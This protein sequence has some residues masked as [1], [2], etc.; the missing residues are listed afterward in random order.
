MKRGVSLCIVFICSLVTYAKTGEIFVNLMPGE[1]SDKGVIGI[2]KNE[3]SDRSVVVFRKDLEPGKYSFEVKNGKYLVVCMRYSHDSIQTHPIVVRNDSVTE[4]VCKSIPNSELI[5]LSGTVIDKETG[6]PIAGAKVGLYLFVLPSELVSHYSHVIK[7]KR[8]KHDLGDVVRFLRRYNLDKYLYSLTDSKG[9]FKTFV[10]TKAVVASKTINFTVFAEGY[11]PFYYKKRIK[12]VRQLKTPVDVGTIELIASSSFRISLVPPLKKKVAMFLKPVNTEIASYRRNYFEGFPY[13]MLGTSSKSPIFIKDK[14]VWSFLYPWVY[15]VESIIESDR[16]I[17]PSASLAVYGMKERENKE[18]VLDINECEYEIEVVS[19][20]NRDENIAQRDTKDDF[21]ISIDWRNRYLVVDS[22]SLKDL[23]NPIKV[24]DIT[25]GKSFIATSIKYGEEEEF[26]IEEIGV[27][28]TRKVSIT[29][30]YS[31]VEMNDCTKDNKVSL[32]LENDELSFVIRDSAGKPVKSAD[33]FAYLYKEGYEPSFSCKTR[34]NSEGKA[35]CKYLKNGEYLVFIH[36]PQKGYFGPETFA[37]DS[38]SYQITLK[39]GKNVQVELLSPE[40][41]SVGKGMGIVAVLAGTPV[42]LSAVLNLEGEKEKPYRIISFKKSEREEKYVAK[43]Y[44]LPYHDIYLF[45]ESSVT[46][47][48]IGWSKDVVLLDKEKDGYVQ[49]VLEY[50]SG[51]AV[52]EGRNSGE[53]FDDGYVAFLCR[54]GEE[55]LPDL[56][57]FVIPSSMGGFVVTGLPPGEYK[58]KL[59]PIDLGENRKPLETPF[60]RVYPNQHTVIEEGSF[61]R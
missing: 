12:D 51:A 4:V 32:K 17:P 10:Y 39:K 24:R 47:L 14:F 28:R 6:I 44:N 45:P 49:L 15:S 53:D 31:R 46:L 33:V 7:G 20:E 1:R 37:T 3:D 21:Y 40:Y 61:R 26:V 22:V 43:F 13:R 57:P 50:G 11:A 60:F 2:L 18:V 23:K 8:T 16:N 30:F 48:G 34:S 59:I 54:K 25:K 35:V 52:F 38:N 5:E 19:L 58:V 9:R 42:V 56:S 29:Y 27:K 41:K 36:H 55:C